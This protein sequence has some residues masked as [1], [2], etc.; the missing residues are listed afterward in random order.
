MKYPYAIFDM[1]GTLLD[2]MAYWRNLGADY[3]KMQGIAVPEDLNERTRPMT[4]EESAAYFREELGVTGTVPEI[5]DRI[6]SLIV[7]NYRYRI[8]AKPGVAEFLAKM[9]EQGVKMCIVTATFDYVAMP[10]LDRLGLTPYFEFVM[11][12]REYGGKTRPDV[13]DAA[14]AKLGGDRTNTMVFEDAAYAVKTVHEAGYYVV[15]VEDECRKD[16]EE[17]LRAMADDYVE[18]YRRTTFWEKWG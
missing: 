4:L 7:D 15:A 6:Y 3:L 14:A 16:W 10:A 8:Q 13:Y 12:C 11:D 9:K 5:V 17:K 18:D 1:D 2:S